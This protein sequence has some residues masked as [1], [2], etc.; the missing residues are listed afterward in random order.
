MG[1]TLKQ[2]GKFQNY[3]LNWGN[4]PEKRKFKWTINFAKI[5]LKTTDQRPSETCAALWIV[6]QSCPTL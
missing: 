4:V 3:P 2:K 5:V 6:A 1:L